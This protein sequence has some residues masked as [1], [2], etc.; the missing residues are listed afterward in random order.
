MTPP[1]AAPERWRQERATSATDVYS[2][3]VI[4]YE[5]LAQE[6]PFPGPDF[7]AQHLEDP[8]PQLDGVPPSL[9]ALVEECLYK[10]PQARPTPGNI[11][12]RLAR[13]LTGPPSLGLAKLEEANHQNVV[14]RGEAE[15]QR[16]VF[17]SESA[18]REALVDAATQGLTHV[19]DALKE[20]LTRAAPSATVSKGIEPGWTIQLNRAELRLSPPAATRQH[21]WAPQPPPSF[22]VVAHA[23]LSLRIPDDRYGY[24]GR[25]HS[26]WYCDAQEAGSYQWF[27]TAFMLSPFVGG[28]SSV[29]PFALDPG[30]Q[31]A[32]AVGPGLMEYQV[33]W[34]F[35]VVSVGDLDEFI[36]R[37]AGW[38]AEAVQGQLH[39]PSHMP[40]RQPRGSW[41][42]G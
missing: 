11:L 29:A 17:R 20:A 24:E 39:L 1:Y 9:G 8:P 5:L 34:P 22:D 26:L 23:Q 7:R 15:R 35:T 30:Q 12:A 6:R 32:M 33:A 18:R 28:T 40:E 3:G 31:A 42:Q 25:S 37:W 2:L 19:A 16:S 36:S 10:A 14:R 21:P 41:R 27:E 13:V 4:A 38:F